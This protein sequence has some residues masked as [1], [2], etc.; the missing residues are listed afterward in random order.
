MN[1]LHSKYKCSHKQPYHSFTHSLLCLRYIGLLGLRPILV[2]LVVPTLLD[3]RRGL[4]VGGGDDL[5][6]QLLARRER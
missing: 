1:E 5:I 4:D 2:T 3:P 6:S